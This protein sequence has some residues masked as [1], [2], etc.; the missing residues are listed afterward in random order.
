MKD[1]IFYNS[2]ILYAFARAPDRR[3]K[4]SVSAASNWAHASK[5]TEGY[6]QIEFHRKNQPILCE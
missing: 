4:I 1:R 3:A 6:R 2:R 5:L